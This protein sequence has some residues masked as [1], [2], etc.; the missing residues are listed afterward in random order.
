MVAVASPRGLLLQ[1]VTPGPYLGWHVHSDR[2]SRRTGGQYRGFVRGV[3]LDD[4][5]HDYAL[6]VDQRGE[7][8]P[9]GFTR[10]GRVGDDWPPITSVAREYRTVTR[11][12]RPELDKFDEAVLA[13]GDARGVNAVRLLR[14]GVTLI[15]CRVFYD[16]ALVGVGVT[17]RVTVTGEVRHYHLAERFVEE[18][19]AWVP[20][21]R[22]VA[23]W[24]AN[25]WPAQAD[26]TRLFGML[27]KE[28]F[29]PSAKA[30]AFLRRVPLDL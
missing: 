21:V 27:S 26:L 8:A 13:P 18:K 17:V 7:K 9:L 14:L 2:A 24:E 28:G 23:R 3:D 25:A 1:V 19:G 10:V 30:R 16:V 5:E 12:E 29:K 20:D 22:R 6:L 11:E 4:R 15:S